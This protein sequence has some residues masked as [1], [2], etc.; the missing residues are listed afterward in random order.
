MMSSEAG[1]PFATTR[2]TLVAAAG[3]D[4]SPEGRRALAEL[5]GTYW[6]PLYAFV[7]HKGIQSAEAQ[8]LVQAFFAELLQHDRLRLADPQRGRFRSFLLAALNH[9]LANQ[10]R[11]EVALKRGGGVRTLPLDFSAGEERYGREP[12]HGWTAERL[13]ERRWAI[14]LL[15]RTL[16]RLRQE[17]EADGKLE[18]F[19]ALKL[20][21]GGGDERVPYDELAGRLGK[22]VGAV[23]VA[24]HRLRKRCGELLRD[25]IAETV[26]SPDEID[27]ELHALFRAVS[28]ET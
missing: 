17:Y 6:Y 21:L 25:E 11:H 10:W 5:C 27:E 24:A 4:S 28:L 14:T 1:T 2:W 22:S 23:K 8:D 26:S 13:Y 12:V 19:E 18:L 15:D 3:Q 20:H 9:F 16:A 7:R